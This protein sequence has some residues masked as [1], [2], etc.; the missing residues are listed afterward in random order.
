MPICTTLVIAGAAGVAGALFVGALDSTLPC[1]CA[2]DG[3]KHSRYGYQAH[4]VRLAVWTGRF[5]VEPSA[6]RCDW[7]GSM[8]QNEPFPGSSGPLA[9]RTKHLFRERLCRIEFW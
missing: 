3:C 9:M 1:R 4:Y 8:V 6:K 5:F 7:S 2:A